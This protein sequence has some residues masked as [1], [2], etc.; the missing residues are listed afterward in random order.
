[1]GKQ[2]AR[3]IQSLTSMIAFITVSWMMKAMRVALLTYLALK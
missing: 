1:M 3:I 2:V